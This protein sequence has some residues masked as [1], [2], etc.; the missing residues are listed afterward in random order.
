MHLRI[1]FSDFFAFE[2]TFRIRIVVGLFFN[3]VRFPLLLQLIT[4]GKTRNDAIESMEKALDS[5]VI[6]GEIFVRQVLGNIVS[7]VMDSIVY[8]QT[9]NIACCCWTVI[10]VYLCFIHPMF[11][12]IVLLLTVFF[13]IIFRHLFFI[14]LFVFEFFVEKWGDKQS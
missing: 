14:Y 12:I 9:W 6:R 4:Y 5:Y 1:W 10:V 8:K 2:K 11:H 13:K 7:I 3:F